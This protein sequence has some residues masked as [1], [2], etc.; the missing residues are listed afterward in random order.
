[1]PLDAFKYLQ[2]VIETGEVA[3]SSQTLLV[4]STWLGSAN[5][6]HLAAF[7]EHPEFES[8][9]GRFELIPV[10]Y[11]LDY[12]DEELVYS[13]RVGKQMRIA[14]A[15]HT[16]GLAARFAVLTRLKRPNPQAYQE[17][18]RAGVQEL[19]AWQKM[20]LYAG[21]TLPEQAPD[22]KLSARQGFTPR[23]E[24]A[25]EF[26]A[27]RAYED[28]FGA[29]P[30]EMTSLLFAAAQVLRFGYLTPFAVL[31]QVDRLC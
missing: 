6:L 9:R 8:F 22:K 25:V 26:N 21:R 14:I 11:L 10:P 28:S 30:R 20:E 1:R 19:S 23:K 5:E 12:R 31:D 15:P 16:F 2:T 3:L 18:Y 4:N 17:E 7:R 13:A 29:S 24:L 27:H